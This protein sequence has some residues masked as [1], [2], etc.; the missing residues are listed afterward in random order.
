MSPAAE[1]T[2]GLFREKHTVANI[3]P[4]LALVLAQGAIVPA[5]ISRVATLTLNAAAAAAAAGRAPE[6][7]HSFS[8]IHARAG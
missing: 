1:V 6:P 2:V 7:E 5:A 8:Q 4:R 3:T